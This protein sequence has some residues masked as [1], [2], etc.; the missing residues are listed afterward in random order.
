MSND[1][2]INAEQCISIALIERYF[3][4]VGAKWQGDKYY[5]KSP[6]RSDSHI[7][8]TFAIFNHGGYKDMSTSESGNFIQLVSKSFNLSLKESAEKILNDCGGEIAQQ[9][10]VKK[11]TVLQ[12]DHTIL[13]AD[14]TEEER[15]NLKN[16]INSK[17]FCETGGF[18]KDENGEPFAAYNYTYNGKIWLCVAGFYMFNA[19]DEPI[20]K[21]D[22]KQKKQFVPFRFTNDSGA[23]KRWK[24]GNP[25]KNLHLLGIDDITPGKPIIVVEGEKCQ[26]VECDEFTL[27]SWC[28]GCGQLGR[29]DFTPLKE[30]GAPVYLWP[31]ND[32][33]GKKAMLAIRARVP[34]AIILNTPENTP[35]KYDIYDA[36]NDGININD[37]VLTNSP[38]QNKVIE[39]D[40]FD[41][42]ETEENVIEWVSN[43]P[44][45]DFNQPFRFLGYDE[46]YDYFLPFKTRTVFKLSKKTGSS[47]K[48]VLLQLA[49]EQF[50]EMNFPPE[51]KNAKMNVEAAHTWLIEQSQSV[52]FYNSLHTRGL[53]I[54]RDKKDIV[55]NNG[56]MPLDKNGKL[57][58]EKESKYHYVNKKEKLRF[59]NCKEATTED[60][61][62]LLKLFIANDFMNDFDALKT[63]CWSLFAPYGGIV[64]WR[65]HIWINGKS[66]SGKSA[67]VEKY[68]APLIGF[69]RYRRGTSDSTT[70]SIYR[71]AEGSL[72]FVLDEMEGNT[73]ADRMRVQDVLKVIRNSSSNVSN[74]RTI[75]N[76]DGGVDT[77]TIHSMFMLLSVNHVLEGETF[78]N[79]FLLSELKSQHGS[80]MNKKIKAC[81]D[82]LKDDCFNDFGSFRRRIFNHIDNILY[83]IEVVR[84][85]LS[86][87]DSIRD[88]DNLAPIFAVLCACMYDDSKLD[89]NEKLMNYKKNV[90]DKMIELDKKEVR[91]TDDEKVFQAIFENMIMI[92][93]TKEN[94]QMSYLLEKISE[95]SF[96]SKDVKSKYE[97]IALIKHGIKLYDFRDMETGQDKRILVLARGH[98]SIKKIM[99][100]SDMG[101]HTNYYQTL[102][103]D[104]SLIETKKHRLGSSS[105]ECMFF[106]WDKIKERFFNECN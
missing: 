46:G 27:I 103:R 106:D 105:R 71:D 68:I 75:A 91:E 8:Q 87:T 18:F 102:K 74:T 42:F 54:W 56:D 58:N 60:C 5:T 23:W 57:I 99:R 76:K 79:R 59:D 73:Q 29:T 70:A 100:E 39:I 4:C 94:H 20:L 55:F 13:Y 21:K 78:E 50:W 90:I 53:G 81:R 66:S 64:D 32:D 96:I 104:P 37:Y 15:E 35:E 72:P 49:P 25:Y 63:M 7:N 101:M 40:N 92:D 51:S 85:L 61:G 33:A 1:I 67:L 11:E 86:E 93:E 36:V 16:N 22:G 45:Q 83:N 6:L 24:V 44:V 47:Q 65:P 14:D 12:K 97:Y 17:F 28:G 19:S 82:L 3:S 62:K 2:F 52:G 31:D 84:D 34:N 9:I 89:T 43:E 77:Q 26:R 80:D 88:A 10:P 95:E 38:K 41:T 48:R 98:K 69:D 30:H